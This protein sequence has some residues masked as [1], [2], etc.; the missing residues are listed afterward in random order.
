[1][2]GQ[3]DL[4][5]PPSASRI[6]AGFAGL[7]AF[8]KRFAKAR[9]MGL[10]PRANSSRRGDRAAAAAS[11][12]TSDPDWSETRLI[13]PLH[14]P[15]AGSIARSRWPPR[16][17]CSRSMRYA[18]SL[19]LPLQ[20]CL[21]DARPDHF[22]FVGDRLTGLVNFRAMGWDTVAGDL[23]RLLTEWIGPNRPHRMAAL[24]AFEGT[25]PL[26]KSE[27]MAIEPSRRPT[28]LLGPVTLGPL[29]FRRSRRSRIPEAVVRGLT[30]G[31]E[32]LDEALRDRRRFLDPLPRGL[33][34]SIAGLLP[35]RPIPG[36][37]SRA[38]R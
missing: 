36:G 29:A 16:G 23:A 34:S 32:R 8:L 1:M 7:A 24:E 35:G 13:P 31:L 14:W 37:W 19:V 2:P 21:R 20:L 3:A 25:L 5:R 10:E 22:L 4:S 17:S 15:D 9:K 6:E 26:I 18:A 12:T 33:R 28:L 30:E 38:F 11:S 27:R